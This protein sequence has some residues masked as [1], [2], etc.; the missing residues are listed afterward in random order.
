MNFKKF[1]LSNVYKSCALSYVIFFLS[2]TQECFR[3]NLIYTP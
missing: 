3:I 1:N 2:L